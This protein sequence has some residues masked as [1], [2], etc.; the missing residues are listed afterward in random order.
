MHGAMS[1]PFTKCL[2]ALA[3]VPLVTMPSLYGDAKLAQPIAGDDLVFAEKDG[4]LVFEAEHFYKQTLTDKRTWYRTTKEH[5]PK[6]EPDGDPSHIGG[7][8]GGAYLEILP[9]TRRSHGDKLIKG[10]NFIN[11]PG[12]MGILS[13]K[14]HITNPGRYRIWGRAYS[15][16]TE[17]N[18]FHVG[19]D[20]AWPASGQRWQTVVKRRWHWESK[21]RTK[22]VHVGVPGKLWLDIEKPGSHTIEISM[23]EDGIELDKFLFAKDFD[24]KPE[25]HG[26][27]P[28]VRAGTLP[29]AF[30]VVTEPKQ[31]TNEPAKPRFPAHWGKPPQIQTRDFV[32]L[33][34][35]YGRGSSTL[36]HW[37]QENL[38]RDAA[39]KHLVLMAASSFPTESKGA[40]L[41]N[42]RF[43][44]ID[45]S[46][47]EKA[48]TTAAFPFPSGRYDV[49]L[50]A[51][52][53][54]DGQSTYAVSINDAEL[55][56]FKTP[57][58]ED[59][60]EE[61]AKYE[62][63]WK[64]IE[65]NQGDVITVASE[66]GS[67]D[68]SEFTRARWSGIAFMP[69]NEA[70]RALVA[71]LSDQ[72]RGAAGASARSNQPA[73]RVR[74]PG[75]ASGERGKDGDGSVSISGE[76]KPWH[77]VTLTLNGP[78]AHENDRQPNP[79]TDYALSV[80]FTH[81]SGAPSY[82]VPGYFAADGNAAQSSASSGNHWRA[83]L[84]PDKSGKWIYKTTFKKGIDVAIGG[85]ESEKLANYSGKTGTF[86]IGAN[87][88]GGRDF[89]AHG[90]LQYVGKSHLRFAE[91][92]RYFLKAG[93]D[94]PETFLAYADFDATEARNAK[95]CPLKT[96]E[97]HV[98]DWNE[99]D[100]TWKN[101]KGK[102]MIGALNY[103]SGK[104]CNVFS[105]LPYNAGGDGD[106]VWPF[107][108][109]GEKFHYDCSKLDQWGIVFDHATTKGLYLHFKLQETEND[110]NNRGHNKANHG[111]VPA[112]LDGGDLGA[113]RK[114]YLREIIAR[115]GHLLALNWNLGE[116]NTQST[117]QQ[118][119]MI[120]YIAEVDAYDH[121][122]V[123]HTFPN[124]QDQVYKPLLG[125]ASKLTGLSIQNSNVRDCHWQVV[126]WAKASSEAGKPW[127][128]A[129][130]EPGNAQFGMPPDPDYPG[131]PPNFDNPS[132]HHT[133]K[134]AL[135]GTIMGGGAGVEYYFGYKLPQNDLVCE[136]W[137]S[138]DLSW[139]YC[140]HALTFFQENN[141][142]FQDM[143][144][145]NE[146]IGVDPKKNSGYCLAKPGEIYL[147]YLPNGGTTEI[148][149][150]NAHR[151]FNVH[152]FNPRT[153]GDLANGSVT[154]VTGGGKAGLGNPPA[155]P[156]ED[157]L[158][159]LR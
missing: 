104:G 158:V 21:Q 103:L 24:Y 149:L 119:D 81:E 15:T 40:Y 72:E 136:D 33:P 25:G 5:T 145:A 91:S 99:G 110:D 73:V 30:P 4:I 8:S 118:Q 144:N 10:E 159:M 153:G 89:R 114:L 125:N 156:Q 112:A 151:G 108:A 86:T 7:A 64:N 47:G 93:A 14:V 1:L 46:E 44:A 128:V 152:W 71:K 82:T 9:D 139:D 155:D 111:H 52:G 6:I 20:G 66:I 133:R 117:A 43:A 83:H 61:G 41:D 109:Y 95:K 55:G 132:I 106:N 142:P 62:K 70:T 100:P 75:L 137:R 143:V 147:V 123:L 54:N 45:P 38:D 146:L 148:D 58:A 120:N 34:G 121:N 107:N 22:E 29:N 59:I 97:P 63:T 94:A 76:L 57:V 90:R 32:R 18:G 98:K 138:R 122:I 11:E 157:W 101:G 69:A 78:F 79:F 96:W 85:S 92:G 68:G 31:A 116:E 141:I 26:P 53:E 56:Q 113:E 129:F 126:K 127:I 49:T 35:N 28:Q 67:S 16:N 74:E 115:F 23:R 87:D 2:G 19:L 39:Q 60:Y 140:R 3:A 88:K 36:K 42:G 131:T 77:K 50:R 154:S 13:Y 130:D 12:K 135:W 84:S 80:E 37:I 17:D 51:A 150:T 27:T 48:K 124:Q 105:F 134:Y 65:V 102:G